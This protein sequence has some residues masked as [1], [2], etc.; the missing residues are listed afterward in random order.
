MPKASENDIQELSYL[1][2][3]KEPTGRNAMDFIFTCRGYI[4]RLIA[5]WHARM[6]RKDKYM[7]LLT[8]MYL[9]LLEDFS[10][11]KAVS[12]RAA[13]SYLD[14]K[15]KRVVKPYRNKYCDFYGDFSAV[16]NII[17]HSLGPYD[18][19]KVELIEEI[20]KIIRN[21]IFCD[22]ARNDNFFVF[23]FV[24][25]FPNINW[26]SKIL[27]ERNNIPFET[28]YAADRKR[29][30]RFNEILRKRFSEMKSGNWRDVLDWSHFER[31]FLAWKIINI[32]P[33]EVDSSVT[34]FLPVIDSWRED[35]NPK[36]SQELEKIAMAEKIFTSMQT[37]FGMPKESLMAAEEAE[38]WGEPPD[39]ISK[40]IAWCHA[41]LE[42]NVNLCEPRNFDSDFC[43]DDSDPEA[44]AEF[45][46]VAEE[47]S[48]WF[49][50]MMKK[51]AAKNLR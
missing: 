29:L 16:D 17:A 25:V 13:L 48:K 49:D 1:R 39:I 20:V 19:E 30:L 41:S 7:E 5:R 27:A 28:R 11:G 42:D 38:P 43:Y 2:F 35:F 40:I 36:E 10:S 8:E 34:E 37:R 32:S 6:S 4:N 9:V 46:E 23:L 12:C 18:F 15:L 26:I 24:H 44:D 21:V 45:E 47:L 22:F 14:C 3:S 50:D 31:S 51:R 33:I